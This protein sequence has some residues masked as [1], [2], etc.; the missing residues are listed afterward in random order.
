MDIHPP[1]RQRPRLLELADALNVSLSLLRRDPCGDWALQGRYGHVFSAPIG[2]QIVITGWSARGWNMAKT[3]LSFARLQNDGDDEGVFT[4]DKLP[5][6]D[7]SNKIR[8][9]VGL[10]KRRE[11]TEEALDKLR[12]N[13]AANRGTQT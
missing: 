5:L 12:T 3:A 2:F 7:E 6:E 13:L 10:R 4:L 9:W 1:V 11:I 8:K